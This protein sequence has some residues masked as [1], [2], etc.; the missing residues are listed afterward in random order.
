M[1]T[2]LRPELYHRLQH[3]FGSVLVASE[4]MAMR[5][6]V[7]EISRGKHR[8]CV[9][10]PG[11]YYRVCCPYC[12]DRRHRLWINHRWGYFDRAANSD[13][14]FLAHC[15]NEHCLKVPGRVSQLWGKLFFNFIR[16]RDLD[17]LHP[18]RPSDPET[19]NASPPGTCYRLDD[20]PFNHAA[21][22]YVRSRGLDPFTLGKEWSVGYVDIAYAGRFTAQDRL[23]IPIMFRGE[24]AGWQARIL[25]D[26]LPAGVPKYYSM[27]GMKKSQLL[28]NYD[29]ARHHP[30]VVICEGPS[31][32]W[33]FGPEAVA[34]LGKSMSPGQ[35]SLI[36]E[37]TPCLV[38]STFPRLWNTAIVLLDE[39]AHHPD[40]SGT[41]AVDKVMDQLNQIN[42]LHHRIAVRLPAGKDPGDF[43]R[44]YLRAFVQARAKEQGVALPDLI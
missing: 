20:L 14:L 32:V 13:N 11:E 33:S 15:Y 17:V 27:P 34:L 28:Y 39:D 4:G 8:R 21:H 30:F 9:D 38:H 23:Y 44:D 36:S 12:L 1:V 22:E 10:D 43:D 6:H 3:H 41:I 5:S 29:Q 31:D 24:L 2:P 16:G 25:D 19:W 40:K 37:G 26:Q 18:G 7:E 42:G 35:A